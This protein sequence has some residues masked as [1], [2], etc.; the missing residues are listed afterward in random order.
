VI[1]E[2]EASPYGIAGYSRDDALAAEAKAHE[3]RDRA[4]DLSEDEKSRI[5]AAQAVETAVRSTLNDA[6]R[7]WAAVA[8]NLEA[9]IKHDM[10]SGDTLNDSDAVKALRGSAREADSVYSE[11]E[12]EL[13]AATR[14]V[15]SVSRDATAAARRRGDAVGR[16]VA[17][18]QRPPP[19]QQR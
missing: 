7:A 14:E 17:P 5:E 9:A 1:L 15:N 16:E 6:I 10:A 13:A 8:R 4:Y 3:D 19:L 12:T 11:V 18:D 2:A